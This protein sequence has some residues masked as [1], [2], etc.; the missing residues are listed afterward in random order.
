MAP[1]VEQYGNAR[2]SEEMDDAA[3]VEGAAGRPASKPGNACAH[4]LFAS[5]GL[6]QMETVLQQSLVWDIDDSDCSRSSDMDIFLPLG[7]PVQD[8]A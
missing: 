6:C 5:V 2:R 7:H 4:A 1:R 3:D 8:V